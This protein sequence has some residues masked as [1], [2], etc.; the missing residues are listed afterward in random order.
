VVG[1]GKVT[2]GNNVAPKPSP[3]PKDL[4]NE[5]TCGDADRE[6]A[7]AVAISQA[8]AT[9]GMHGHRGLSTFHLQVV[10]AVSR[11]PRATSFVVQ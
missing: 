7:A 11:L 3:T 9:S 4:E 5:L 2:G 10:L 6:E 8:I 1:D